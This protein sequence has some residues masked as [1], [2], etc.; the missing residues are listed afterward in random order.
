M[1]ACLTPHRHTR[2]QH[3]E[4]SAHDPRHREE[5]AHPWRV[6]TKT[7]NGGV[8]EHYTPQYIRSK[9]GG[10]TSEVSVDVIVEGGGDVQLTDCGDEAHWGAVCRRF[11]GAGLSLKLLL[12]A[13]VT[14]HLPLPLPREL[15]LR[16]KRAAATVALL[17]LG[18]ASM[19][20]HVRDEREYT[21]VASTCRCFSRP[22]CARDVAL[23]SCSVSQRLF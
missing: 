9:D 17:P 16:L 4:A 20:E 12:S 11:V 6:S 15:W 1:P 14:R 13:R 8:S 5:E 19:P 7:V 3:A 18:S 21:V 23:C 22:L 10:C 2:G